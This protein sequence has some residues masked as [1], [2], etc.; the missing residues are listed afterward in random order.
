MCP[1]AHRQVLVAAVGEE[2]HLVSYRYRCLGG[3]SHR[4]EQCEA[5]G[6]PE[7]RRS[8]EHLFGLHV[9]RDVGVGHVAGR[10][11]R[12]IDSGH[13]SMDDE[14]GFVRA[15]LHG[16]SGDKELDAGQLGLHDLTGLLQLLLLLG[17]GRDGRGSVRGRRGT[18][19]GRG[20]H[21]RGADTVAAQQGKRRRQYQHAK[22]ECQGQAHGPHH[23]PPTGTS[24]SCVGL[25]PRF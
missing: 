5:D 7:A 19:F 6:G 4:G 8:L 11:M 14:P 13:C 20:G 15:P 22:K 17:C 12:R 1:G 23:G 25:Q 10:G 3:A 16:R 18:D 24:S 2:E 9:E 21:A